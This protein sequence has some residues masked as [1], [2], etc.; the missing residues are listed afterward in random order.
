MGGNDLT[1]WKSMTPDR[2]MSWKVVD[3]VMVNAP[4]EAHGVNIYTEKRFDDFELYCEYRIGEKG[5]SG[6]FLRGI[7]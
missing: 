6:V 7:Y 4:T 2:P 5:N 1:G 3:G